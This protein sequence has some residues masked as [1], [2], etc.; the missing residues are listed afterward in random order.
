[1]V[2]A[3]YKE[4]GDW[5]AAQPNDAAIRG[6]WWSVFADPLLD[7]LMAQVTISNQNLQVAEA[8][9]R[10]AKGLADAAHANSFPPS[11]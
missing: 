10:Q 3:A 5:Q 4:A 6:N 8:R 2:P 7:D 1:V 9:Y 11:H